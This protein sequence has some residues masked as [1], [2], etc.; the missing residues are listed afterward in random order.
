M[1]SYDREKIMTTFLMRDIASKFMVY[2]K[3]HNL[4]KMDMEDFAVADEFAT[5]YME[6]NPCPILD[7][8]LKPLK[9]INENLDKILEKVTSIIHTQAYLH[10]Y[11]RGENVN[12]EFSKIISDIF[13][14]V[15]Q[16]KDKILKNLPQRKNDENDN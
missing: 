7:Y 4:T 6:K 13:D 15:F 16:L 2:A 3:K 8:K 10:G 12:Y 9:E 14:E 1:M 5:E 11:I